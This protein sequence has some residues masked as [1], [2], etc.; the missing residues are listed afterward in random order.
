MT[1]L[2]LGKRMFESHCHENSLE[3][4]TVTLPNPPYGIVVRT[5]YIALSTREGWDVITEML[6]LKV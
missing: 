2:G 4:I 5:I 6:V 1:G 3:A